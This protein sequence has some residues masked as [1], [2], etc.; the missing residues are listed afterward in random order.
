MLKTQSYKLLS[1]SKSFVENNCEIDE[2]AEICGRW[3]SAVNA[4]L[5]KRV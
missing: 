5:Q 3:G 2:R 1:T 4:S